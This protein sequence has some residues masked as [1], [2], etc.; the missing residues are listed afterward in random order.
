MTSAWQKSDAAIVL[1]CWNRKAGKHLPERGGFASR[2]SFKHDIQSPQEE[3]RDG[4]KNWSKG[5]SV[6]PGSEGWH[7]G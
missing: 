3:E 4:A 5:L 1:S 6:G 2:W 7:E